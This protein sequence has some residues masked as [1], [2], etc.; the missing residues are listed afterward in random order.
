MGPGAEIAARVADELFEYL[1]AP[2]KRL[3]GTDTPIPQ[4]MQL[5]PYCMPQTEDVVTAVRSLAAW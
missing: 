5:E 4:N 3:G 1:D 2:V